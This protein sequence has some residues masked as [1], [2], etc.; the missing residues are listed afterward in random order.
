VLLQAYVRKLALCLLDVSDE[1]NSDCP[2]LQKL[3]R[4]SLE[5]TALFICFC[6]G[7]P[8]AVEILHNVNMQ[9]GDVFLE[10]P[11]DDFHYSVLVSQRCIVL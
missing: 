6:I 2:S 8:E 3:Q 4:W 11:P 5:A 7:N 1:G 10:P 9:S